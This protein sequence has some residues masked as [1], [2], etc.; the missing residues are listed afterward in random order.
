MCPDQETGN[1]RYNSGNYCNTKVDELIL[2]ARMETGENRRRAMLREVEQI[3]YDD[4]A[5]I[6]LHWQNFSWA[7][8]KNL[9]IEGIVTRQSFTYIG[10]LVLH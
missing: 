1:G 3:L 7:G 6:P 5:F 8:R 10:D 4:A 2:A 9:D